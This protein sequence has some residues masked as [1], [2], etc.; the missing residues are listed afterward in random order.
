MR[1]SN[2]VWGHLQHK[3]ALLLWVAWFLLVA[4]GLSKPAQSQTVQLDVNLRHEIIAEVDLN[5]RKHFAHWDGLPK[6]FDYQASFLDYKAMASQMTDRRSFSLFTEAFVASLNNGH[7]Q[8]NDPYLYRSDPGNLGFQ[9]RRLEAGW[10]V[11]KS[12]RPSLPSGSVVKQT[13]GEM[14]DDFYA[15][16]RSQLNASNERTR[17]SGLS[18]YSAL[19]PIELHFELQTG[20]VLS[21]DRAIPLEDRFN[22]STVDHQW[23]IGNEVALL[24]I[25]TFNNSE[26]ERSAIAAVTGIYKD[27]KHII[28]DIRG[29][30]GGTTPSRLGRTLLRNDWRSWRTVRPST[31]ASYPRRAVQDNPRFVL[32]VDRGCGSACED[33]AMPFSLSSSAVLIRETTGGSRLQPKVKKW[34]N[35]ME[36]WVG[37]KRQ[38]FP[39]GSEFEGVGIQPDIMIALKAEDFRAGAPDTYLKTALSLIEATET[40]SG[41]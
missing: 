40:T 12:L 6:S 24:K 3:V 18:S 37:V 38:W 16:V 19:F 30:G 11:T 32:L 13:N 17:Q 23:L 22:Q 34:S 10:T 1:L 35:G 31:S 14:F 39:D 29:N 26:F 20:D 5:L 36:L 15:R 21:F 25:P 8:F 33:F 41:N 7:T 27:A 4:L 28:I 2:P 9:L